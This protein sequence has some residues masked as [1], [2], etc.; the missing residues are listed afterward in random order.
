MGLASF[1]VF[2]FAS[3]VMERSERLRCSAVTCH[4]S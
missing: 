4:L 2:L 1:S 3:M